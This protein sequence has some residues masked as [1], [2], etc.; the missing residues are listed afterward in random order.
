MSV[1][2]FHMIQSGLDFLWFIVDAI[3]SHYLRYSSNEHD[4]R[5]MGQY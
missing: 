1:K 5:T 4:K 2:L 3:Q